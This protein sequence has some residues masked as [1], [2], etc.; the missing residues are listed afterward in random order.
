[1]SDDFVVSKRVFIDDFTKIEAPFVRKTYEI[2]PDDWKKFGSKLGLR[3][4]KVYLVTPEVNP[5]YEWVIDHKDTV[6]IEKLHGSNVGI[7]TENNR[8]IHIQNRKNVVDMYQLNGGRSFLVEG[9]LQ[10]IGKDYVLKDGIQYGESLGPKLNGNMYKLPMH[11]WY[12]FSKARESL[13]YSSFHKY[14]KGFWQWSEWFRDT[15]KSL[16]YCRYHKIPISEMFERDDVPFAEGVVFYND[17]VSVVEGKPRMA[18]LRRDMMPWLYWDKVKIIGL[19][20]EWID[21]GTS[22][23]CFIKGYSP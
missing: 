22:H 5:G 19:E 3:E 4:P 9:I 17:T 6:A 8:L 16:F 1:M 15:L 12:P 18:K 10:A 7:V 21:Y 14:E 23:G 13:K 20:K 2:D 11:L